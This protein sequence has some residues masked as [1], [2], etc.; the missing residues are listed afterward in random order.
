MTRLVLRRLGLA[1]VT[2]F[3]LSLIVFAA[4][5]VLPGDAAQAILGKSATPARLAALRR[6]LHLNRSA[7]EQYRL[8]IGGLIH[9][10]LGV[11]LASRQPVWTLLSGRVLNS[12]ILLVTAGITG[13]IL[14]VT[15]G[16]LAA[17]RRDTFTDHAIT[18]VTLALVALPEFVVGVLLA[19]V[20]GTSLLHLLPPVSLLLPGRSRLS[21]LSAFVLPAMTLTIAIV[22]YISRMMRASMVEVLESDYVEMAHLKGIKER[23]ILTRYALRNAI[24]PTLQV[25]ALQIAWLAGGVVLVEFVFQYPGI[26]TTLVDAVANRDISV[27]QAVTMLVAAT[28][29]LLNLAADLAT[30][31]LTPR[32]RTEAHR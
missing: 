6:Q 2:L 30:I 12:A 14:G 13:T 10:Y 9:G 8:W 3:V 29:V 15:V 7:V 18:A 16:S 28:Y 22:P 5:Q 20:F 17:I 19:F 4:T 25:T 31:L 32:L 11:S 1:I 21:Q 26:G 23:Y 27:V 24:V